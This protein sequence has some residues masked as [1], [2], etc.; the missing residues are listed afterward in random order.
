MASGEPL[1]GTVTDPALYGFSPGSVNGDNQTIHINGS[2]FVNGEAVTYHSKVPDT[3]GSGSVNAFPQQLTDNSTN[4]PTTFWS[5]QLDFEQRS[6]RQSW[7]N[8]IV[9]NAHG[10]NDGDIVQYQGSGIGGLTSGQN[11]KVKVLDDHTIQLKSTVTGG[12]TFTKG[13]S[14]NPDKVSLDSGQSWASYGFQNGQSITVSGAATSGNNKTYTISSMSG[15]VLT[16]S[17]SGL[18][19]KSEDDPNVTVDGVGV[20]ALS[21]LKTTQQQRNVSQSLI[22]VTDLPLPLSGGGTLTSSTTYYVVN[23]TNDPNN[24]KLATSKGG[25]PLTFNPGA[26][27]GSASYLI[28]P[29]G[30]DLSGFKGQSGTFG[31]IINLPSAVVDSQHGGKLIRGVVP[32]SISFPTAGSGISS[33]VAQ[34]SGGGFIGVNGNESTLNQTQTVSAF[35]SST[36]LTAGTDVSITTNSTPASNL[37][38]TNATGGAVAV[39][40]TDVTSTT[41]NSN[42]AYVGP[43]TLI[44][45]G[46]D[47][48]LLAQSYNNLGTV[49]TDSE[50]GGFAADVAPIRQSITTSTPPRPSTS[51][52][53]S[54]PGITSRSPPTPTRAV[55]RRHTPMAV[56]LV[57]AAMPTVRLT[58][59]E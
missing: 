42:Q 18:I 28:G 53:A 5:V 3:F 2:N 36:M 34:G 38:A 51:M 20:I 58:R 4:P 16:L 48:T 52:P 10:F 8:N 59:M 33:I 22:R 7:R 44:S 45:A 37:S 23:P 29:E 56:G 25:T 27:S 31:L 19:S 41:T 26:V 17:S 46:H 54:A 6:H 11:Y 24:F 32:G 12:V 15:S 35:V 50:A 14:G 47:F 39:G 55:T 43:G 13:S 9:I 49:S 21:P 1:Y 40:R 30:V 57:A